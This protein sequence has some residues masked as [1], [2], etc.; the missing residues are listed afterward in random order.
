ML[1]TQTMSLG[2]LKVRRINV[3]GQLKPG[4]ML[5]MSPYILSGYLELREALAMLTNMVGHFLIPSQ[6]KKG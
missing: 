1:A 3:E 5:R 6:W 4:V 2:K